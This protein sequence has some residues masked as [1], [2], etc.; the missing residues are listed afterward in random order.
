MVR[1][2]FEREDRRTDVN[3][4]PLELGELDPIFPNSSPP[5]LRARIA[6]L[7]SKLLHTETALSTERH[8]KKEIGERLLATESRLH[9][10][11]EQI[12][13]LKRIMKGIGIVGPEHAWRQLQAVLTE[14]PESFAGLPEH[15]QGFAGLPDEHQPKT[16][17]ETHAHKLVDPSNEVVEAGGWRLCVECG[18][19]QKP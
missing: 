6:E 11:I 4:E 15:L 2:L 17:V 7:E 19:L 5:H 16:V 14:K 3:D 18:Y 1:P 8:Q 12:E 9:S 13:A 10:A